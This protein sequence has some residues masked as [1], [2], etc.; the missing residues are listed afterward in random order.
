MFAPAPQVQ[1]LEIT[2]DVF[3]GDFGQALELLTLYKQLEE[4]LSRPSFRVGNVGEA[5]R[6]KLGR[7][8]KT[9]GFWAFFCWGS[10]LNL[11]G[12]CESEGKDMISDLKFFWLFFVFFP[13]G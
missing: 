1:K 5:Y 11:L 12:S 3:F 9:R 8:T 4:V 2:S 10:M 7:T 6:Q 13:I